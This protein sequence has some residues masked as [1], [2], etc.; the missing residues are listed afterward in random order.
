MI[1][2]VKKAGWVQVP[3]GKGSHRK[4]QHPTIPGS[5]IIPGQEWEELTPGVEANIR[6]AA[7]I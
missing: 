4:F 6:K 3:G 1:K 5:L 2:R 7:G